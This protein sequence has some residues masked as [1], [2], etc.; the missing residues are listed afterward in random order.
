MKKV[1]LIILCISLCYEGNSQ[2]IAGKRCTANGYYGSNAAAFTGNTSR[3]GGIDTL[4]NMPDSVT[5]SI[6]LAGTLDSGYTAGMNA[7]GDLGYAERYDFSG[8]DSLLQVIGVMT[9]FGGHINPFST[10]NVTFFISAVGPA[11]MLRPTVTESGL[12]TGLYTSTTEPLTALGIDLTSAGVDTVKTFYFTSPTINLISSFFAGYTMSYDFHTLGGDT[13]ALQSSWDWDRTSPLYSVSGTD[14]T[15]YD[16]MV[17]N[18][19]AAQFNDGSWHDYATSDFG[20]AV[21]FFIFPIVRVNTGD[22]ELVK[23][24]T[25]KNLTFFGNFPN[26]ANDVTTVK[27]SL[28]TSSDV[29]ILVTDMNGQALSTISNPGMPAGA[30]TVSIETRN[31]APGDYLCIVRNAAGGGMA[32]KFSVVH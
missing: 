24:I 9:L 18:Q 19:N 16:T 28:A 31:L 27:F 30:N 11:T 32:G 10:N 8:A 23:G 5:A 20:L 13:I 25:S 2:R 21:D 6:Y 14:S 22:P 7:Y 12:P 3:I 29:T 4:K 1:L 15:G 26:P 17:N